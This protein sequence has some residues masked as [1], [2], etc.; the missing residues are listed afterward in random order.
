MCISAA[1]VNLRQARSLEWASSGFDEEDE[2]PSSR[3]SLGLLMG[4]LEDEL[5]TEAPSFSPVSH[6]V[7]PHRSHAHSVA[8]EVQHHLSHMQ[9]V[10]SL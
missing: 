10:L 5:D 8:A 6:V 2:L 3:K 1:T 9:Q 4:D 7:S